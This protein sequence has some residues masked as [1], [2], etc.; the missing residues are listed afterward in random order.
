LAESNETT[1]QSTNQRT[2]CSKL[3]H[4][5]GSNN[6]NALLIAQRNTTKS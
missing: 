1:N 6:F 3:G 2:V 4:T 5:S